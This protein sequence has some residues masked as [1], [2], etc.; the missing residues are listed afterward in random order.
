[1]L[2]DY[3]CSLDSSLSSQNPYCGTL[4]W[5]GIPVRSMYMCYDAPTIMYLNDEPQTVIDAATT[6]TSTS[7]SSSS[8]SASTTSSSAAATTTAS[9]GSSGSQSDTGAIVG[10]VV[11]GVA[12]LAL[13][14]AAIAFFVLRNRREN[15]AAAANTAADGG[16]G[17]AGATS[18]GYNPVPPNDPS[19]QGQQ[20]HYYAAQGPSPAMTQSGGYMPH[21]QQPSTF[22]PT[23]L[24]ASTA[25]GEAAYDPRQSYYDPSKPHGSPSPGQ[26]YGEYLPPQQQ[27]ANVYGGGGGQ[28]F[29]SLPE[30]QQAG[31]GGY[32]KYQ[33]QAPSAEL[34]TTAP[35]GHYSNPVEAPGQMFR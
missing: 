8:T 35:S 32:Q 2:A 26:Q 33:G 13:I 25:V 16:D 15:K 9:N 12:L 3:A 34:G 23:S 28:H 21:S 20:Q 31:N 6:T 17:A 19:Y 14:A 4:L 22:P 5:T 29:N 30:Q 18:P 7:S 11:G 10:G 24:Y 27:Y 1:M